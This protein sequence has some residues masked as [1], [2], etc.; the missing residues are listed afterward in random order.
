MMKKTFKAVFVAIFVLSIAILTLGSCDFDISGLLGE[1][2][3]VHEWSEWDIVEQGD[4]KNPGLIRRECTKCGAINESTT[5]L[6]THIESDWIVD[7]EAN[8]VEDGSKHKECTVCGALISTEQ[9]PSFSCEHNYI[10]EKCAICGVLSENAFVYQLQEDNTY[11]ILEIT[12]Y[13]SQTNSELIIC[14]PSQYNGI[15]VTAMDNQL[16]LYRNTKAIFIPNTIKLIGNIDHGTTSFRELNIENIWVDDDNEFYHIKN[17]CLIETKTGALIRGNKNSIIPDY[18]TSINE[19]AFVG[20]NGLTSIIIP[21]SVTYIGYS[22]FSYCSSLTSVTIPDSVTWIGAW[23]F[24]G[25]S[26]LTSV[27]IG[28]SVTSIDAWAFSNCSSLISITVSE[29]NK[30]FK[31][32]DG[33]L[34]SKDGKTLIQYAIGKKDTSFE[35]PDSVTFIGNS[36][37]EYCSNLTS[38]VIPDS[39]TS[40]GSRAFYNTAYYNNISNWENGVLYIDNHLIEAKTTLSGEYVIKDGTITIA[41]YAFSSCYSLTSIVIPDSVTSIGDGA[42]HGCSSLTSIVI[43]DSVTSIG[44]NA[45][46][47]CSSL[48]SVVIPDSVTSI[49]MRA[50]Y[51]CDSLTSI[52]IPD[53]VTSIGNY[54]FYYC[55]KL[56]DVYYTGTEEEWANITID[57]YYNGNDDLLNATIHYNY[58]PE[59]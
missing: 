54:A 51:D 50:F 13:Y 22:A 4:C 30:N 14:I 56:T 19:H 25:C 1:Y 34:Y 9:I 2:V 16:L 3:C 23:A 21:N 10:N 20:C 24:D 11:A 48:T 57:N 26:S 49:G 43:P 45:F 12:D 29:D 27:V 17:N 7:K 47:G 33:N 18:V 46:N 32:I 52:V 39:V 42:F 40:I 58:V 59:E 15:T 37:F 44:Y 28:D 55:D 31:S 8:Y 41:S 36:A 5:S 53:S 38:V 6:N 35:I